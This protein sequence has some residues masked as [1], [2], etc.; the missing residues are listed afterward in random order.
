M[1]A[2]K[3]RR[4]VTTWRL[5]AMLHWVDYTVS[6]CIFVHSRHTRL[7]LYTTALFDN[8]VQD[9]EEEE[10][11]DNF[12]Q[13]V[14]PMEAHERQPEMTPDP[15]GL[16]LFEKTAF[17]PMITSVWC[18]LYAQSRMSYYKNALDG[19]EYTAILFYFYPTLRST[20]CVQ[21]GSCILYIFTMGRDEHVPL[22]GNSWAIRPSSTIRVLLG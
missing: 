8:K 1:E 6:V 11:E 4:E 10:P 14:L 7:L 12:V 13:R 21:L 22:G 20:A 3:L 9:E 17:I 15:Y 16:G 5:C 2:G 18:G 19:S